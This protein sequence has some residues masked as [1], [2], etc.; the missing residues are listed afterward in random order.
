MHGENNL[1]QLGLGKK[2]AANKQKSTTM[3][4]S[5]SDKE[6]KKLTHTRPYFVNF[7]QNQGGT[8]AISIFLIKN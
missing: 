2:R 5:Y 7:G 6:K 3:Q 8:V 4:P 1:L